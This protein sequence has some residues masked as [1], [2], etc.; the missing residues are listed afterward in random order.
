M[1]GLQWP[2]LLNSLWPLLFLEHRRGEDI[3][4][5]LITLFF[6][7]PSF[8]AVLLATILA[9]WEM[10]RSTMIQTSAGG[11][12][13]GLMLT[14]CIWWVSQT[15]M[16]FILLALPSG[17][18]EFFPIEETRCKWTTGMWSFQFRLTL[19]AKCLFSSTGD[20]SLF[21]FV[22]HQSNPDLKFKQICPCCVVLFYLSRWWVRD[23]FSLVFGWSNC[24]LDIIVLN[25]L[26]HIKLSWV[27]SLCE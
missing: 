22:G 7:P 18:W 10:A 23:R 3:C 20:M 14:D 27:R 15:G 6:L 26:K 19:L 11:P 17:E 12:F 13:E 24:H 4:W 1:H 2:A 5:E 16:T 8:L 25:T 21:Q 9:A